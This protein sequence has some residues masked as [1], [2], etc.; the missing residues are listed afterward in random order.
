MTRF[1]FARA[2]TALLIAGLGL[3]AQVGA[4]PSA[5]DAPAAPWAPDGALTFGWE[6][7]TRLQSVPLALQGFVSAET[8]DAVAASARRQRAG[9]VE[10]R[11]GG[12][13][14]L[15]W[16]EGGHHTT[17]RIDAVAGGGSRGLWST[18]RLD[19]ALQAA[20]RPSPVPSWA[21]VGSRA[22]LELVTESA[23]R[24]ARVAVA[25]NG[26]SVLANAGHVIEHL[27]AEGLRPER[28]RDASTRSGGDA[29][30]LTFTH[31]SGRRTVV[32]I[33]RQPD[34]MTSLTRIDDGLRRPAP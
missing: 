8:P 29:R 20:S 18:V 14:V 17:L 31:P 19:A 10:T 24:D 9:A 28:D 5:V 1:T 21:P 13:I 23:G 11:H 34:G 15:G 16:I 27:S 2:R 3:L 6:G 25:S 22:G 30:V 33:V 4:S 12:A 26:A 7:S 32:T